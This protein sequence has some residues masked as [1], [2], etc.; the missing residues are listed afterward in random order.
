MS[1]TI[2][3]NVYATMLV[4]CSYLMLP[5][6]NEMHGTS[7]NMEDEVVLSNEEHYLKNKDEPEKR[8]SDSHFSIQSK[9]ELYRVHQE[10]QTRPDASILK[11]MAE[12][13]GEIAV[14]NSMLEG[15]KLVTKLPLSGIIYLQSTTKTPEEFEIVIEN[16]NGELLHKVHVMKLEHYTVEDIFK[17]QLFILIP[18]HILVYKKRFFEYNKE[19]GKLIE[20]LKVYENILDRLDKAN[21]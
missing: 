4:D 11:R 12:Y 7:F 19:E 5:V 10:C 14:E 3:A 1:K 2:F 17:K 8:V 20:L 13:G 21:R 18:F 15:N 9:G 16:S 6:V